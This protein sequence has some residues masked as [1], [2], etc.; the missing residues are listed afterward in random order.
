ML[1]Q[2]QARFSV[3]YKG[4]EVGEG[5]MDLLVERLLI[6]ELKAVDRL[7]EVHVSQA[8]SYLKATGL[9]LALFVNF[10]VPV[11]MRGVKRIV[12][13]RPS[14]YEEAVAASERRRGRV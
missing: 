13:N 4:R 14:T 2:R 1:F 8:L 11:L 7:N 9:S 3:D 6:V 12:L 5:R 10:N